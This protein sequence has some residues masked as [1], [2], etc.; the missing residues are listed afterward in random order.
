MAQHLSGQ[1]LTARSTTRNDEPGALRVGQGGRVYRYV[2]FLGPVIKGNPVAT[3]CSSQGVAK[4][5]GW[6]VTKNG[7]AIKSARCVGIAIGSMST[8]EYGYVL[9]HGPLGGPDSH[10]I[11]T[12]GGVAN[13][14]L[15]IKDQTTA[16]M[17]DTA[18][19]TGTQIAWVIG[20]AT[21]A[22]SGSYQ[23]KGWVNCQF[24]GGAA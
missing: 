10:Y 12:D 22:D 9:E 8:S 24:G 11:L 15:L 21:A 17:A 6:R 23:A 19:F 7:S 18:T 2:R 3:S 4:Q 13:G 5:N 20:K 1:Q 16:G 14:D